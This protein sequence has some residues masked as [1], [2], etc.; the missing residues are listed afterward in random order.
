MYSEHL[1]LVP[2]YLREAQWDASRDGLALVKHS[3][4][5]HIQHLIAASLWI[6]YLQQ[7]I[8]SCNRDINTVLNADKELEDVTCWD[9]KPHRSYQPQ[10]LYWKPSC[11]IPAVFI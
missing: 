2:G 5:A 1:R 3:I 7:N 9:A 11:C 10:A 8:T 6:S 4:W